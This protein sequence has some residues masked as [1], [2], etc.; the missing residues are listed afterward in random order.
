MF[1]LYLKA[2]FIGFVIASHIGPISLL[3]IR[4]A[5]GERL[6]LGL[7]T[8]FGCAFADATLAAVPAFGLTFVADWVSH[9]QAYLACIA[10]VVLLCLGVYLLK[11]KPPVQENNKQ[12]ETA[13]HLSAFGSGYTLTIINPAN[14]FAFLGAFAAADMV[15]EAF[16]TADATI[17]VLGCLSGAL[18]AWTAAVCVPYFWLGQQID[19]HL[20][21]LSKISAFTLIFG[22]FLVFSRSLLSFF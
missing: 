17:A 20:S 18:I 22:G 15:T 2:A 14:M 13:S 6:S 8:G 4:R 1:V 16:S 7:L 11:H 5:L 21:I 12:L 19:K 9:Y 10:G 3:A